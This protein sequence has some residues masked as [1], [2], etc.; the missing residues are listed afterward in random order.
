ML[1]VIELA[2]P[3]RGNED[4]SP[5]KRRRADAGN[6]LAIVPVNDGEKNGDDSTTVREKLAGI[7]SQPVEREI[8]MVELELEV[9]PRYLKLLRIRKELG[10]R[11]ANG[12]KRYQFLNLEP[13]K[14]FLN[15]SGIS[16]TRP[17][18]EHYLYAIAVTQVR[19]QLLR[20]RPRLK[21]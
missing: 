2:S 16:S 11:R 5:A 15:N 19:D 8:K 20:S 4:N 6:A 18:T 1:L 9:D 10:Y 17:F 14:S 21:R 7:K 3:G 12:G 13:M